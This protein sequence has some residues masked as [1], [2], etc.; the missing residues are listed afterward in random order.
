[1][2]SLRR[3][4]RKRSTA[5]DGTVLTSGAVSDLVD[6]VQQ[7]GR[8]TLSG[9]EIDAALPG[10][11]PTTRTVALRTLVKAHRVVRPL[12]RHEFFVIVPHEYYSIGAPPLAWYVDAFMRYLRQPTYYVGLLTAAE[13]NGASHFAAQETQ[14]IV[15]VQLRPL[16]VGRERLRFVVNHRVAATPVRVHATDVASVRVS[17]PA[18]TVV[19][20]LRYP[21]A[22]GGLT[23]I[24]TVMSELRRAISP[25]GL[26]EALDAARDVTAAQRL[27]YV[28][29]RLGHD[30]GADAAARWLRPHRRFLRS[31]PLD[32]M[33][34]IA[35]SPTDSRWHIRVNANLDI[36]VLTSA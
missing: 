27:G 24:T 18:A 20:L 23:T 33:A 17:T 2:S 4:A 31:R 6:R 35:G 5:P 3:R 12:P 11:H 9:D 22:V 28:L 29:E 25:A 30:R 32:P 1:L 7:S 13:W 34:P 14:I 21:R 36:N 19:D 26:R 10:L 16:L 15:P 8:Y